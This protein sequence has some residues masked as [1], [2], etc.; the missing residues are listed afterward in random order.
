MNMR[1]PI[2]QGVF[3]SYSLVNGRALEASAVR[4][5]AQLLH[6]S[7]QGASGAGKGRGEGFSIS[8][9]GSPLA[10]MPWPLT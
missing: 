6:C 1:D 9:G 3:F 8:R 4:L 5:D 7:E 10:C 2:L